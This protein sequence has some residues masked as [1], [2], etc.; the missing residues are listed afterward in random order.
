MEQEGYIGCAHQIKARVRTVIG[1]EHIEG[2]HMAR[3]T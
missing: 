2:G 1:E 3:R